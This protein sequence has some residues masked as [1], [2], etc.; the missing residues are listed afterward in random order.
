MKNTCRVLLKTLKT[1]DEEY[2]ENKRPRTFKSDLFKNII[3]HRICINYINFQCK[4][5]FLC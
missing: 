2:N 5:W 3:M 1:K 4:K